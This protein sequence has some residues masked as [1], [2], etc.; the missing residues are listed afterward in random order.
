MAG[1][2]AAG[3]HRGERPS[4]LV[5]VGTNAEVVLGNRD[6]L[7]ACAGA[8]GPALEGGVAR[9]GVVARP[10]AIEGVRID[11]QSGE[12]TLAVIPGPDGRP[13]KP[14]G[15][16]G[17]GLLQLLAQLYLAGF[18][19]R[20]GKFRTMDHPRCGH[21]R[22]PGYLVAA[23]GETG[24]GLPIVVNEVEIDILLRSKAAMYTILRTIT[25]EVGIEFAELESFFVA[26]AF[27]KVIDPATA[28]TLGMLP[29]LPRERF[30]SLGNSSL[31]GCQLLLADPGRLTE[32]AEVAERL[33][34]L[35]L[36]VNQA[37][38]NRFSAA[39]FIPHTDASR[40]PSVPIP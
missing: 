8:A 30:R 6:W 38:M 11:P 23:A 13:P 19:D 15:L 36:N 9:H 20:R 4:L 5:D 26:G 39:R 3:L 34:Y 16:C 14:V 17:S 33:T 24:D 40:F 27:G 28:I 10:G 18:L 32:V 21:R 37:L 22:G 35:E 12:P 31:R 29:D 7:L 1:I 2:L 25:L